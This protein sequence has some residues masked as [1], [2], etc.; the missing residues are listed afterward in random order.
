MEFGGDEKNIYLTLKE[1]EKKYRRDLSEFI[2]SNDAVG[3]LKLNKSD[4]NS[5]TSYIMDKNVKLQNGQTVSSFYADLN[6][7]LANTE[8]MVQLAKLLKLRDKAGKFSFKEIEKDIETSVTKKIKNKINNED[9]HSPSS[10]QRTETQK[11]SLVEF[12]NLN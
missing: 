2:S 8:A 3:E 7:V 9:N 4:K 10:R 6:N 11:K 1:K 5:L 12:L